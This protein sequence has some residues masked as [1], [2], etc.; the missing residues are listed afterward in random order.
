MKLW[1]SELITVFV[2]VESRK[3]EKDNFEKARRENSG[4]QQKG[5]IL[6]KKRRSRLEEDWRQKENAKHRVTSRRQRTGYKGIRRQGR[7]CYQI[8]RV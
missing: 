5:R 8:N 3:I 7:K 2:R 1:V 6:S 4:L